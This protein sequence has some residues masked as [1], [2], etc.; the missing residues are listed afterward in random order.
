M[1]FASR[2]LRGRALTWWNVTKSSHGTAVISSLTWNAFKK[3]VL[4]E[5]CNERAI[6]RIEEEFRVLKKGSMSVREYSNRFMEKLDL[7]GHV[8]PSE[9]ERVKAYLNGLPADMKAMVR[10]S[11]ASTLREAIEES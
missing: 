9:R 6:D 8:V 7:V 1:K 10:C 4:D 11:K 5:Y 2:M 3:K